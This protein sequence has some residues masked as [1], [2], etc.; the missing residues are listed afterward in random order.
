MS[1]RKI[2]N[3][4]ANLP[5]AQRT[6]LLRRLSDGLMSGDLDTAAPE[7]VIDVGLALIMGKPPRRARTQPQRRARRGIG[8]Y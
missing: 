8:S 6:A 7:A 4:L 3:K 5:E 2:L 1:R